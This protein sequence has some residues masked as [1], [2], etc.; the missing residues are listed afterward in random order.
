MSLVTS[1]PGTASLTDA[2]TDIAAEVREW[3]T[4]DEEERVRQNA[5]VAE[6]KRYNA[7]A[8]AMNNALAEQQ[9]MIEQ[10]AVKL[11]KHS[12]ALQEQEQQLLQAETDLRGAIATKDDSTKAR[13]EQLRR[14]LSLEVEKKKELQELSQLQAAADRNRYHQ[15]ED[16][17]K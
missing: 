9:E 15:M 17:K 12:Q 6:A 7:S 14:D 10:H 13:L 11:T 8:R 4:T 5:D 1:L 16:E 2:R 3:I